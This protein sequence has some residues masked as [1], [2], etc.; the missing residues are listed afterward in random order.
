MI[1]PVLT[2]GLMMLRTLDLELILTIHFP[3]LKIFFTIYFFPGLW[4][5]MANHLMTSETISVSSLNVSDT[6]TNPCDMIV[7]GSPLTELYDYSRATSSTTDTM[8]SVIAAN[9]SASEWLTSSDEL[10]QCHHISGSISS[11]PTITDVGQRELS[12]AFHLFHGGMAHILAHLYFVNHSI[13]QPESRD[14]PNL[15]STTFS[16]QVE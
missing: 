7:D 14:C 12:E 1:S 15:Y 4:I 10:R 5:L 13:S 16:T 11:I 8:R 2:I 6:L 3:G 9:N